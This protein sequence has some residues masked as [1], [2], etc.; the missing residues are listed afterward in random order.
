MKKQRDIL[1][2]IFLICVILGAAL[3]SVIY[4]N[5]DFDLRLAAAA[6]WVVGLACV[7]GWTVDY[8]RELEDKIEELNQR[9]DKHII[10]T[11]KK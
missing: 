11:E 8:I 2:G 6:V 9:V 3:F 10:D 4:F 7:I 5:K 1:L